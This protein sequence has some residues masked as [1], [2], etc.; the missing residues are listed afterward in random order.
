MGKVLVQPDIPEN[1]PHGARQDVQR[2]RKITQ[3]LPAERMQ[4]S[5]AG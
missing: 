3:E 4:V 1:L 2:K 5:G